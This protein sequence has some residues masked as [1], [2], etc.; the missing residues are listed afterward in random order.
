VHEAA[1]SLDLIVHRSDKNL[2][3]LIYRKPTQTGMIIPDSSS[4]PYE[5]LSGVNYLLNRLHACPITTRAKET[6]INTVQNIL[7]NNECN[8]DLI[9]KTPQQKQNILTNPQHHKWATFHIVAKK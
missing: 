7:Q 3:F 9:E 5:K 8:T 2:R 4:H 6:E 1:S